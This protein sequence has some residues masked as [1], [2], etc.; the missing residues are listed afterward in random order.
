MVDFH[1]LVLAKAFMKLHPILFTAVSILFF[2]TTHAQR[3]PLSADEI[4]QEA[5]QQAAKEKKNVLMIFH[6]SWCGWCHKM[7]SSINDKS[8]NKFFDNNY[9]IRHLVVDES[10][11]KK[12][13]ENPGADEL[14][15]KYHGD[16]EGIPFW[17]IFDK[18]G[19]LLADSQ[20]RPEGVSL[21]TKGENVGCPAAEKE[22]VHFINVMKKTS[23]INASEQAA[24]EKRFRQNEN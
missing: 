3:A 17:L 14:R 18:D 23:H 19:N 24:I 8:C 21:E 10:K 2:A 9:V 16:G 15:T 1:F 4:M 7:D 6:A 5:V 13:L 20:L 11:D 22:V 12:N